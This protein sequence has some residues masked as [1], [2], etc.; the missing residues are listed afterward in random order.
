MRHKFGVTIECKYH[1]LSSLTFRQI[2]I[3]VSA[4]LHLR[5]MGEIYW[6]SQFNLQGVEGVYRDRR[7]ERHSNIYKSLGISDVYYCLII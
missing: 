7:V 1:G 2:I 5:F 3:M 6:I 4:C